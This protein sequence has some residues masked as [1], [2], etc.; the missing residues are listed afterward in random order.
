MRKFINNNEYFNKE[1][2]IINKLQFK[3]IIFPTILLVIGYSLLTSNISFAEG[4]CAPDEP[5][6]LYNPLGAETKEIPDLIEAIETW[7]IIIAGPIA[8]GMI[9]WGAVKMIIAAGDPKGFEEGKNIILYAV[10]GYAIILVGWGIEAVIR[11]IL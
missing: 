3:K 1:M 6:C 7:L 8:V 10:I 11:N 2:L 4:E 5:N 9:I